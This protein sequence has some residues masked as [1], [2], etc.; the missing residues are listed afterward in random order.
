MSRGKPMSSLADRL[1][2]EADPLV[3]MSLID[4]ALRP[5]EPQV[6]DTCVLQNLDWVDRRLEE[7]GGGVIWDDTSVAD[8]EQQY[9]DDMANDLIAMGIMYKEFEHRSGYPWL[10]CRAAV[11]EAALLGG[12]KGER[13]RD[14]LRF[15]TGHQDEWTDDTYPRIAKGLLL[16]SGDARVSSLIL[17]ALGVTSAD[18]VLSETGPLRFLS[19]RGDRM[20]AAQ[21]LFSNI[22]VVL[23]TDRATFWMHRESL[24]GLG[25]RVIRPSELLRLYEPYWAAMD[26][27]FARRSAM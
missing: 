2:G 4:E 24:I 26:A 18:E 9:G 8:L 14:L 22:P 15:L 5:P 3:R 1:A 7:A 13:L 12:P 23:T 6:L 17:R 20:V 11:E 21:A 19:D 25:L 16:S 10:V 27:E